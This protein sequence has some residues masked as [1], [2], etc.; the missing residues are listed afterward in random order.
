[1]NS[2]RNF[3]AAQASSMDNMPRSTHIAAALSALA[4]LV[5]S[6]ASAQGSAGQDNYQDP[7]PSQNGGNNGS[8]T[9]PGGSSGSN[10]GTAGPSNT[11]TGNRS[12]GGSAPAATTA[13]SGGTNGGDSATGSSSSASGSHGALPRTGLDAS[14]VAF[15]GVLLVLAGLGL[16]RR[17][18]AHWR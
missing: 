14:I 15:A 4:L 17:I 7:F 10:S 18:P 6:A 9:S 8:S 2:K 1:M 16:R 11:S 3:C 12:T 5:P 13:R